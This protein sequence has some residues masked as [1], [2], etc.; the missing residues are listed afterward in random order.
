MW[1]SDSKRCVF[2]CSQLTPPPSP[3]PRDTQVMHIGWCRQLANELWVPVAPRM[4][5]MR[6]YGW[7]TVRTQM[8]DVRQIFYGPHAWPHVAWSGHLRRRWSQIQWDH[9]SSSLSTPTS[10]T[11]SEHSK[12]CETQATH[13]A[14]IALWKYY[15]LIFLCVWA[16]TWQKSRFWYQ[17]K[18]HIGPK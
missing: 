12:P 14:Y 11:T 9:F 2:S 3:S 5:V 7:E 13:D 8:S 18:L 4:E 6:R 1:S 10:A 15:G 16:T 17:K